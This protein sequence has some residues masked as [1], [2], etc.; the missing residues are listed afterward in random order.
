VCVCVCACVHQGTASCE[1]TMNTLRY[2]NRVKQLKGDKAPGGAPNYNAYMPHQGA[3]M[4]VCL[5]MC[6]VFLGSLLITTHQGA[7]ICIYPYIP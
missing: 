3:G 6:V 2:A 1:H 4:Y 5:C 7:D